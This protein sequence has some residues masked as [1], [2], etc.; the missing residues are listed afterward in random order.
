MCVQGGTFGRATVASQGRAKV[1]DRVTKQAHASVIRDVSAKKGNGRVRGVRATYLR[2]SLTRDQR[3][4]EGLR[5]AGHL[6]R[7]G[8]VA[9]SAAMSS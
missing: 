6:T 8:L 2:L 9:G 7:V 1:L 3:G 4:P 5:M